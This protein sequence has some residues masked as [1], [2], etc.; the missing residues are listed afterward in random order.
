MFVEVDEA[1]TALDK[2]RAILDKAK[3]DRVH[4]ALPDPPDGWT[5]D[6]FVSDRWLP[7][8][9]GRSKFTSV[10]PP[11]GVRSASSTAAR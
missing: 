3:A 8:S 1:A 11:S 5:A 10:T 9:P 4:D 7:V 2:A 6:G